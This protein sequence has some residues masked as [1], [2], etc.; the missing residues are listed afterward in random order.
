M[1]NGKSKLAKPSKGKFHPYNRGM[2]QAQRDGKG[3]DA[4]SPER[5][6]KPSVAIPKGTVRRKGVNKHL[7]KKGSGITGD[8]ATPAKG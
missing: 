6:R 1:T 2:S 8:F 5:K 7:K 3:L 4:Y